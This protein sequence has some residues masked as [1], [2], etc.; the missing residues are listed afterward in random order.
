M[1]FSFKVLPRYSS[2]SL[3]QSDFSQTLVEK[4]TKTGLLSVPIYRGLLKIREFEIS[5]VW[6]F[7]APNLNCLVSSRPRCSDVRGLNSALVFGQTAQ[8][9]EKPQVSVEHWS[10]NHLFQDANGVA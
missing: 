2:F 10:G 8:A 3:S 4:H 1:F 9:A 5:W 7:F 6:V